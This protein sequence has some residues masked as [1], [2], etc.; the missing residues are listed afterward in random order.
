MSEVGINGK[1]VDG[2][3]EIIKPPTD[4]T[5][6]Q[7]EAGSPIESPRFGINEKG[8]FVVQAHMSLGYG[9]LL[10]VLEEAKE[11]LCETDPGSIKNRLK[12]AQEK[13]IIPPKPGFRGF[14]SLFKGK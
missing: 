10:G 13:Q 6:E 7:K 8:Y 4:A 12:K 14:N 9:P 2:K 11:F 5:E 1:D 3:N